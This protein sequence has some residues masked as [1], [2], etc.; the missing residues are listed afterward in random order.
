MRQSAMDGP[1]KAFETAVEAC[2]SLPPSD[3]MVFS[4]A[5]V[6]PLFCFSQMHY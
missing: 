5:A 6:F 2:Q 4:L 3:G 1:G